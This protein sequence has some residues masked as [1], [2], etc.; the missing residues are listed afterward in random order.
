M[1]RSTRPGV[2]ILVLCAIGLAGCGGDEKP[3]VIPPVDN[4]RPETRGSIPDQTLTVGATKQINVSA[5][6]RD[7][8]GD[9][10]SYSVSGHADNARH[11]GTSISGS[12]LTIRGLSRAIVEVRVTARDPGGLSVSSTFGVTISQAQGGPPGG[13]PPG[14]G[15]GDV[16]TTI[17]SNCPVEAEICVRDHGQE[18]GDRV[19]VSVN[20]AVAFSGGILNRWQCR[21]VPVRSGS[22]RVIF[23]ALNEGSV[24]PNTGSLRITGRGDNAG[25]VQQWSHDA[26]AGSTSSLLVT[27][28]PSG[29][30]CSVPGPGTSSGPPGGG[31]P[32]GGSGSPSATVSITDGCNDGYRIEWK[33]YTYPRAGSRPNGVLPSSSTHWYTSRVG[34]TQTESLRC[35]SGNLVCYGARGGR[36]GQRS[37]GVGLDGSRG[38][39]DC[40][41]GC[42]SSGTTRLSKR[43]I[44]P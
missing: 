21:V 37:W 38:C 5:Y 40:C 31:P 32:G 33:I 25:R 1:K 19:T 15:I 8:D 30:S 9:T 22:N 41:V 4:D 16:S 36:T 34:Q 18:D 17:P 24:S 13:G 29:G 44:C 42:P 10:L 26:N 7:P 6:F 43:L 39:S 27:I 14:G 20:G 23:R 28:G 12:T 2:L 3:K 35:T 11:I